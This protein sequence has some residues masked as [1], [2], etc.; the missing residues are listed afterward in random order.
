MKKTVYNLLQAVTFAVDLN[1][2]RMDAQKALM[3]PGPFVHWS[4]SHSL[5]SEIKSV[6]DQYL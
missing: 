1:G 4:L 3:L 2:E 5:G 6:N